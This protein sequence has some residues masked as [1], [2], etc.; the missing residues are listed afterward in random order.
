[1][2]TSSADVGSSKMITSA[3]LDMALKRAD[4]VGADLVMATDPDADR[5]GIA[6]RD[7][8]G[9]LVLINGN[10]TAALLTYYL[11]SQWSE[12]GKL[13]GKEYIAKTI[14]TTELIADM[15]RHYGV[16]CEDVLTGFKYIADVIRQNEAHMTFI[17]GGEESYGF[18]IGDFVRDKDAVSS[19]SIIAEL[20]AW[21]KSQGKSVYDVLMDIHLK[22]SFYL[23]SLINVVR[24]GKTGAEEIQA[25]MAGFRDH[26]PELINETRVIWIH[27]YQKQLSLNR[28]TGE[29]KKINLPSSNVL[30]FLLEDGSKVSVRPSGTEP[31]IKFYFSVFE[32]L[33]KRENYMAIRSLLEQR[34]EKLKKDLKLL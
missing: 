30:Q 3:A 8:Q 2:D 12:K 16:P 14:V 11:L 33:D 32:K 13:Q 27:D 4:E 22:F 23:E 17:G 24:K 34:I 10:Q 25:M 31:K 26:P 5:V 19:C 21:A 18:M 15:A 29:R 1:M 9:K 28:V 6:V 7:D 20:A